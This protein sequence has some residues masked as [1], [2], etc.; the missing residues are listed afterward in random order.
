MLIVY[1]AVAGQ[2]IVKLY[3]AAMIPGFFLTF[4]YLVYVIGWAVINPKVAPRLPA[5]QY[6]LPVPAWLQAIEG[7]AHRRRIPR[8]SLHL[9][10]RR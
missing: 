7:S 8:G 6:R 10:S 2:S 5:D 1:A 3:A 4:L 9:C